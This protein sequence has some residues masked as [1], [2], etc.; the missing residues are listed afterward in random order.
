MVKNRPQK[1]TS[2]LGD[3]ICAEVRSG[4]SLVKI[5]SPSD[6]PHRSQVYRWL[7]MPS[8]KKFRD[9]FDLAIIDRTDAWLEE[10]VEIADDA[11]FDI[12]YDDEGKEVLNRE[13]I[14]RSKLRVETRLKL[15]GKLQP[16][17][18]GDRI[19]VTSG[20]EPIVPLAVFTMR[21]A[22]KNQKKST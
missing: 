4:K 19:D 7:R 12:Q 6:M 18:Y 3:R 21:P 14:Q 15:M 13:H 22:D 20:D 9:N 11:L 5:C 1:Y 8:L 16:K 10:A 17:K 2:A